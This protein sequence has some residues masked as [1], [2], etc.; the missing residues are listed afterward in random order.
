MKKINVSERGN[1]LF[2][3]LIAVALFAALSY[4]VT[5]SGRGSGTIDRETSMIAAG[6]ITQYPASLRTAVTRMVITGISASYVDFT[7]GTGAAKVFDSQGGGAVFQVPPAGI[8]GSVATGASGEGQAMLG[9][10]TINTW[11]YKD[12]LNATLGYYVFGVGTDTAVS[13]REMLA[14]L[15][16]LSLPVCQQILKGLSDASY[17]TPVTQATAVVYST[18]SGDGAIG[19]GVTLGNANTFG[20]YPGKAFACFKNG[21]VYDYYHALYEQ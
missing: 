3:I 2:L 15:R 7:T 8:G 5:Q 1:A 16:D 10:Q 18:A 12:I 9:A 4:A 20:A 11:G 6:Q 19:P 14:Y 21:T 13:G 17:T